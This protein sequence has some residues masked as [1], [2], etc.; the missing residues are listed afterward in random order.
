M[1]VNGARG[2]K[3]GLR[4]IAAV[5][6]ALA[7]GGATT[8]AY[9]EA[10]WPQHMEFE[11]LLEIE[12]LAYDGYTSADDV[13]DV[14]VATVELGFGVA[15][16]ERLMAEIG[17]LY[18]EDETPFDVDVAVIHLALNDA[19]SVSAGQVYV[20]FGRYETA[21]VNDPFTLELGETVETVLLGEYNLGSVVVTGYV[22]NGDVS[23]ADDEGDTV[24]SVG[25]RF[26]GDMGA[27]S[28]GVD[29]INNL[30]DS[31][32]ITAVVGNSVADLASAMSVYGSVDLGTVV[33]HGE[34]LTALDEIDGV[35]EPSALHL[36]A[37]FSAAGEAEIIGGFQRTDDVASLLPET[38]LSIGYRTSLDEAVDFGAE[39]FFDEDYD[40][41]DG[42]TDESAVGFIVNVG[43]NF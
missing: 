4:K 9:A 3:G 14:T 16:S 27:V 38:R 21:L 33:V 15:F 25:F 40:T 28:W 6:G 32:G 26:A 23:E 2:K 18:E 17:F 19:L 39:I 5:M 43:V 24:N 11:G 13:E 41:A 7:L 8:L 34:Y 36:E 37:V 42:G 12:A 30:A 20:P 10:S 35:R 22:F 29:F 1:R 31:D